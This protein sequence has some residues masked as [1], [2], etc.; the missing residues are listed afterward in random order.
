MAL[1]HPTLWLKRLAHDIGAS[2]SRPV[3]VAG[4]IGAGA[5]LSGCTVLGH[6]ID[7]GLW[8]PVLLVVA[9]IVFLGWRISAV[10]SRRGSNGDRDNSSYFDSGADGHA[11]HH[12]YLDGSGGDGGGGGDDGGSSSN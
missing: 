1:S 5:M 10:S 8:F 4:L 7:D 2:Y 12:H 6:H 9:F 11:G 3:R